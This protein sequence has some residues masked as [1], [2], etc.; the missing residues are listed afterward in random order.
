MHSSTITVCN[1]REGQT[2]SGGPNKLISICVSDVLNITNNLYVYIYMN[3]ACLIVV[4]RYQ[5]NFV[6][7][8][9]LI[10]MCVYLL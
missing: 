7:R 8:R 2:N 4:N 10:H 3:I 1:L 9:R 6:L 5:L